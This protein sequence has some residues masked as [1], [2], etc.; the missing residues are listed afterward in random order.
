[1]RV[2]VAIAVMLLA[3]VAG[4][5]YWY[6][7]R[8]TRLSETDTVLI[9]DFTNTAGEP[10]FDG[11]LREA[12]AVSL[13]QS[14]SLNLISVEK[15]G[16]AL[17]SLGQPVSTQVTKELAP[18][19][20]PLLGATV[21]LN[22]SIAK[23]GSGYSLRLGASRCASGDD[24]AGAKSD[25]ADKREALHALG[26]AATELRAKFGEEPTSLQEFDLPLERATTASLDALAA[27]TEGRRLVRE[28]GA[29]EAV[30]ALK[31]ATELDPKFALA[32]S[33]LAVAYYNLN[34]NALAADQ[35]RQ[36]FELADRQTVRDRLHI[37]TLYYDLATGDVQKAIGSYK[38][39]VQLYPRD[40]IAK[41]N[42]AS[43][44]FLIGD[45]DQAATFA[46]QALRLDPGSAAW[47]ENLATAYIALQRLE[48]AQNVIDQAFAR[49]LDDPS[50][51]ADLYALA[52]LRGDPAGMEREMAWSVGKP[53]G[54]DNMLALQADTEAYRGHVQKARELSRKAVEVAQNAQLN[55]PA[56]IW[57]GIAALREAVYGNVEEARKGADKVMEIAP[58]SRDAQI[59]AILVLART[60]DVRRAQT[61]MD[62]LVAANVSNTIVQS[63]WLPTVRAQA[64]MIAQKPTEALGLL[65]SVK[66]YERGQ[67]IGNL[68]YSCMIPVYL[69]AE[70]Y[71]GAN[72]GPQALA[73]FQK[74]IDSKGVVG[75]CWSGALAHLGQARAQAMSGSTGAARNSYQEFFALWKDADA[76]IPI[77]KTARTEF[78]KLK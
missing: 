49:K 15:V 6:S 57:Q 43:E 74:L 68:S 64:A 39:W 41:G 14:P 62:D 53:G 21:Y 3:F 16:E 5:F 77:L 45:Y 13:A 51:H 59:L 70:A 65:D 32:H 40:D 54:E 2:K 42:L 71:L 76:N 28:K 24:I 20:C 19:L 63:A 27:F 34:Q 33:N 55:E 69:R 36:A 48:E 37:T 56:A 12:L 11:A 25:A 47:Y 29:M 4:G 72:R 46:Q 58:N 1:M 26:K 61:M 52:F 18:K 9:G 31:K 60:G 7:K 35:I 38:E 75:N 67:L 44:Y 50:M 17:R 22:G 10:I 66:P 8:G 23:D 78:A 73:E 30:P